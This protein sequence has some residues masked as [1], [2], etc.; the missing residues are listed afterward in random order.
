MVIFATEFLFLELL[1]VLMFISKFQVL[2]RDFHT[3]LNAFNV[4][5]ATQLF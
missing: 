5:P 4:K 1:C 3:F 2:Y